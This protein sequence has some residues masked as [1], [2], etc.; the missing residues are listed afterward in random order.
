M[1]HD[2]PHPVQLVHL[3]GDTAYDWGH[4]HGALLAPQ[5]QAFVQGVMQ[6]ATAAVGAQTRQILMG[7]ANE[8]RPFVSPA[9]FD[10]LHGLADGAGVDYDELLMA[11]MFPELAQGHCSMFG[12]WGDATPRGRLVQLRALDYSTAAV[13]RNNAA[14]VVYHPAASK[15][16]AL[17]HA[18]ANV[19]FAGWIGSVTGFSSTRLSLSQ[20]GVSNP[21]GSFGKQGHDGQPFYFMLRD[22]LQWDATVSDSVQRLQN[23]HRTVDILAGV[24]DGKTDEFRGFQL[25]ESV[26]NVF[27]DT[28]M[29][30]RN[31]T[32][33]KRMK[34]VVYWGMD[35]MCPGWSGRMMQV[36]GSMH[37]N[38][39]AAAA[40][41]DVA[42]KV[43]T[44]D[45]HVAVYEHETQATYV[46]FHA[47]DDPVVPPG[48]PQKAYQRQ[49]TRLRMDDLFSVQK[50]QS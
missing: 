43:E 16:A 21:D 12:A 35:F 24:G 10:E 17:G 9:V 6:L 8:T 15:A 26:C 48:A 38:I 50:P 33:H 40:I 41:R 44:G 14:V 47:S 28:D 7:L 29:M 42:A 5:V 20:I 49:Y 39:T 22:V 32:W 31:D 11:H 37:G 19:G 1:P 25:S 27:D 13:F 45:L 2:T 4:A 36:L 3:F 34:D 23:G 46:S 18:W 30:P